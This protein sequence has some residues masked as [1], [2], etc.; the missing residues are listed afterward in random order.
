MAV[1]SNT[2][3][4]GK[5]GHDLIAEAMQ[6]GNLI[7][8]NYLSQVLDA[9]HK[10]TVL[11]ATFA[12]EY[13]EPSH[14]HPGEE[15]LYVVSGCGKVWLDDKPKKLISG[16]LIL[17]SQGVKKAIENTSSSEDLVILAYLAL[18]S[19]QPVLEFIDHE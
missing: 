16:E 6:A 12:P 17:V 8:K 18:K 15:V 5:H 7:L 13:R 9:H 2:Y 14:T 1:A 11:T 10:I 3:S 19:E 4:H